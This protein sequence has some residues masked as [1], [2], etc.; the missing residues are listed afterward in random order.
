MEHAITTLDLE[1]LDG[2]AVA[3]PSL[4]EFIDNIGTAPDPAMYATDE[5]YQSAFQ[6]YENAQLEL[7]GE[8]GA[9]ALGYVT[10]VVAFNMIPFED[11][12]GA[13]SRAFDLT[14][15]E[16]QAIELVQKD[17]T[18][19]AEQTETLASV[20]DKMGINPELIGEGKVFANNE[21]AIQ[22]YMST[23]EWLESDLSSQ[24]SFRTN[25]MNEE[26]FNKHFNAFFDNPENVSQWME[27]R[28][29]GEVNLKQHMRYRYSTDAEVLYTARPAGGGGQSVTFDGTP[30]YADSSGNLPTKIKSPGP[31]LEEVTIDGDGNLLIEGRNYTMEQVGHL[32]YREDANGNLVVT[33]V[34]DLNSFMDRINVGRRGNLTYTSYNNGQVGTHTVGYVVPDNPPEYVFSLNGSSNPNNLFFSVSAQ[35]L[36]LRQGM[37][38][39]EIE[40]PGDGSEGYEPPQ[41]GYPQGGTQTDNGD[42]GD[43]VGSDE[44][45]DGVDY[46]D[47]H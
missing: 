25:G 17:A 14:F 7:L 45:V 41:G 13:M 11:G 35:D 15:E 1:L 32:E 43:S 12:F 40:L 16:G 36:N 5:E 42:D 10:G 8:A 9:Y 28:D 2:A 27:R 20:V 18:L 33:P 21:D 37:P 46:G 29:A 23:R 31:F 4:Q 24:S 3:D 47:H 38:G 22:T 6:E 34:Y 26:V 39:Y 30:I 19:T 44:A